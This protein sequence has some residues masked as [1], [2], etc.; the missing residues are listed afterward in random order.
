MRL[1]GF[2]TLLCLSFLVACS[3]DIDPP[4][5]DTKPG[6]DGS[7]PNP[8]APVAA[9]GTVRDLAVPSLT[10]SSATITFTEVSDG[11]SEPA[12]YELRFAPNTISWATATSS[13]KGSCATPLT[14]QGIGSYRTCTAN[15]LAASTKYEFQIAAFRGALNVNP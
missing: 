6:S 14:G 3:P 2:C 11:T 8:A 5:S 15:G 12:S 4:S 7:T 13:S 1:A 10:D 9:P